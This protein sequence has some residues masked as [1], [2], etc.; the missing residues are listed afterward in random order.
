MASRVL[1]CVDPAGEQPL[2]PM[3]LQSKSV[4]FHLN[5]TAFE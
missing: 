1:M 3:A 4:I 2:L 5:Q